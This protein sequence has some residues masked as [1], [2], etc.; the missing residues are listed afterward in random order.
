M[1]QQSLS[2]ARAN[3]DKSPSKT[4]Q[5]GSKLSP[6]VTQNVQSQFDST[7]PDAAI[8]TESV[9]GNSESNFEETQSERTTKSPAKSAG[10]R[11]TIT[12]KSTGYYSENRSVSLAKYEGSNSPDIDNDTFNAS[13]DIQKESVSASAKTDSSILLNS[14]RAGRYQTPNVLLLESDGKASKMSSRQG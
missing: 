10:M 13:E 1:M 7:L 4:E 9:K 2:R 11:S 3:T 5:S 12:E 6:F 14:K 8:D